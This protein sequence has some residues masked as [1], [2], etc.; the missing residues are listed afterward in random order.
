MGKQDKNNGRTP[1]GKFTKGNKLSVGNEGG[2][3]LKFKRP[4]EL[5]IL[6]KRYFEWADQTPWIKNDVIRSGDHAGAPLHIPTQRPYTLVAL[7]H[8]LG[9]SKACWKDY[10]ERT[11]FFDVTMWAREKIENQQIEG[12]L[13]GVF[14]ANLTAR[15][16]GIA[17]KKQ[18]EGNKEAPIVT[19]STTKV[20]FEDYS[21]NPGIIPKQP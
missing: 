7:C 17:E 6:C 18:H 13:V 10:E 20:I 15:I 8:H 3:P 21:Q 16:Q 5:E 14:N 12:A 19:E 9:I 4:K 2:R 11:E 1:D